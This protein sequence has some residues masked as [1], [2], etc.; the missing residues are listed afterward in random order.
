MDLNKP[1]SINMEK[2]ASISGVLKDESGKPISQ[3]YLYL[4]TAHESCERGGAKTGPDGK[5]SFADLGAGEYVVDF[6]STNRARKAHY[7]EVKAGEDYVV[8]WVKPG[9]STVEGVVTVK[10]KPV[11]GAGAYAQL[12]GVPMSVAVDGTASDGSYRLSL[13]KP[14]TYLIS[15]TKGEWRQPDYVNTRK[16]ASVRPGVNHIDI[17]LPGGVVSGVVRDPKT[18]KPVSGA[19]VSAYHRAWEQEKYGSMTSWRTQHTKPAWWS[20]KSAKTDK[21]GRFELVGMEPGEW[22][23]DA[24]W[25]DGKGRARSGVLRIGRDEEKTGIVLEPGGIGSAEVTVVDAR[26]GEAIRDVFVICTSQSGPPVN[27]E[28]DPAKPGG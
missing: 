15:V 9:V 27:P 19:S 21:A 23:L 11:A 17:A 24:T 28:R 1:L 20:D 16:S 3:A 4:H 2:A 13:P 25:G 6:Y 12:A 10:G 22:V 5:F 14:G 8:D 18:K 26:T 7:A